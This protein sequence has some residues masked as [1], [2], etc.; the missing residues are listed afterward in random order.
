MSDSRSAELW[1]KEHA[2]LIPERPHKPYLSKK[3]LKA[4]AVQAEVVARRAMGQQ[5]SEI[6]KAL[7]IGKHTVSSII[8]QT[9]IDRILEDG[10]IGAARRIPKSLTVIDHHLER[11]SLTAAL[12]ILNPLVLSKDA[13]PRDPSIGNMHISQTIQM[14][15][16]PDKPAAAQSETTITGQVQPTQQDS[17]LTSHNQQ[18]V[19]DAPKPDPDT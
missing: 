5:K 11:N 3:S 13:A 4:P 16:H 9:E 6:Q 17:E 8:E 1:N 2:A 19:S 15:L 18:Y 10:R 12:A 14:L 7:G